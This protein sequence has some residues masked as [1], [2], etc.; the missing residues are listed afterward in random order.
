MSKKQTP[1]QIAVQPITELTPEQEAH[2]QECLRRCAEKVARAAQNFR[3]IPQPAKK[4]SETEVK[5]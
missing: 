2:K 3:R 5:G 4:A 1:E